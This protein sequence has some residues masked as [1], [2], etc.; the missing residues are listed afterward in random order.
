MKDE[1]RYV[2]IHGRPGLTAKRWRR[3]KTWRGKGPHNVLLVAVDGERIVCPAR[4]TRK[5]KA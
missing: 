4:C 5:V 1:R 3:I 2:G